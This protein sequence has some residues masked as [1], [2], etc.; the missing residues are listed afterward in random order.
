MLSQKAIEL[1]KAM[2][3]ND[4]PVNIPMGF[5]EAASEIRN[6]IINLNDTRTDS[7]RGSYNGETVTKE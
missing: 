4:S 7:I 6:W 2:F 5:V 1:I 3:A